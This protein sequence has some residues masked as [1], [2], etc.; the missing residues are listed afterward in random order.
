M[1][2]NNTL[3]EYLFF[4]SFC[5]LGEEALTIKN[6]SVFVV[7]QYRESSS[8]SATRAHKFRSL[9]MGITILYNTS[10]LCDSLN[11]ESKVN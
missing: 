2:H 10:G 4:F 9:L 8:S 1:W 5:I 7:K 3:F 6:A 11:S